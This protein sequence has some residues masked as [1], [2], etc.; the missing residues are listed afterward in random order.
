M[1]EGFHEMIVAF[2]FIPNVQRASD[3]MPNQLCRRL[4]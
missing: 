1:S 3:H 2:I 4:A